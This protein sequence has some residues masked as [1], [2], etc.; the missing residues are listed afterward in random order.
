[1]SV[2]TTMDTTCVLALLGF[3]AAEQ[4]RISRSGH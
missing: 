4:H 1:M 3:R 2:A